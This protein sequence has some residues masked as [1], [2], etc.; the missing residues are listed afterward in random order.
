M[1]LI[2]LLISLGLLWLHLAAASLIISRCLPFPWAITRVLA[3]LLPVLALFFFEHFCGLGRLQWLWP[4]SSGVALLVLWAFQDELRNKVWREAELAFALCFGWALL[5]KLL[6]PAIFPTSER[7]TDMYF[8]ANYVAGDTLPPL[9]HWFAGYRFNFYYSFQHYGGALLAR[10]FDWDL[11]FAYNIAFA[12]VLGMALALAWHV[13]RSFLPQPQQAISRYLL[14]AALAFGGTGVSPFV[15]LLVDPGPNL[16]PDSGDEMWASA[17]FIG[18]YDARVNTALGKAWFGPPNPLPEPNFQVRELPL[19]NFGY[20]FYMGDYHPPL[21]GFLLLFLMLALMQTLYLA[22]RPSEGGKN[23]TEPQTEQDVSRER[24]THALLALCGPLMLVTNT[25]VLPMLAL[26]LLAWL[27]WRYWQKQ[28][29][30]WSALLFGGVLG[31]VL[32]YPFLNN[33]IAQSLHTPIRPVAG[34]DRTPLAG[35]LLVMW[36]LLILFIL[37]IWEAKRNQFALWC[38]LTFLVMMLVGEF[39]YVDDPSAARHERTNTTMKWWGWMWSGALLTCGALALA[40]SN[41]WRRRV[42]QL[43]LLLLC[44]YGINTA[45]LLWHVDHSNAGRLSGKEWFTQDA[46]VK[47]TVDHLALSEKG[48]VLENWLGDSYTNQTLYA[49]YSG[50]RSLLGWPHHVSLWRNGQASVWQ[51]NQEIRDFYLYRNTQ[52]LE[53]LLR[54]KVRYIVWGRPEAIHAHWPQIDAAITSHYAWREFTAAGSGKVG[55]WE[56]RAQV[57]TA[58][59]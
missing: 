31:L 46:A 54:N 16:R 21:G 13:V 50:Q 37:N 3:I 43:V 6:M 17:R 5:W 1:H 33:F 55:V 28:A 12:L 24:I 20:H 34:I 8:M 18:N 26:L 22:A 32:I 25:W 41:V 36:P 9:D 30:H 14:I 53:W 44:S 29:L 51:L 58:P 49:L 42:A 10:W 45:R 2:H 23:Q 27:V 7:V 38:A 57:F 19:E 40:S 4:I 52:P 47:N 35:F 56:R 59:E 15:R 39:M 48:V 11:G